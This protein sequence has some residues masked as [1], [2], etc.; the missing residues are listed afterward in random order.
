MKS[1]RIKYEENVLSLLELAAP[2]PLS[3]LIE[4]EDQTLRDFQYAL[5]EAARNGENL[6]ELILPLEEKYPDKS[7]W[8]YIRRQTEE[9]FRPYKESAFLRAMSDKDLIACLEKAFENMIRY[10]EPIDYLKQTLGFDRDQLKVCMRLYST[11]IQWVIHHRNSRRMFIL[12]CQKTFQFSEPVAKS[13]WELMDKNRDMLVQRS[14][15][16]ALRQL[17]QNDEKV[18]DFIR[19]VE[20]IDVDR[21]NDD[22]A[23]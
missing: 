13:L 3:T 9:L 10:Q 8:D 20:D 21:D 18:L 17:I 22:G 11:M 19:F 16:Q 14:I 6:P 5:V 4:K 1:E 7:F 15:T 23:G 2:N 12:R